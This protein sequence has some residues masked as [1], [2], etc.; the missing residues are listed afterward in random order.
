MSLPLTAQQFLD[1]MEVSD[2]SD[3]PEI[4]GNIVRDPK[5]ALLIVK[6]QIS[7]LR[8]LS[9]NFINNLQERE[10]GKWYI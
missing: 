5:Q 10:P 7:Q 8:F 4:K 1:E 9:N 3:S 2:I 6:S